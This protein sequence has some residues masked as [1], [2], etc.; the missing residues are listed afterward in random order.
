MISISDERAVGVVR[1]IQ[2][3][4]RCLGLNPDPMRADE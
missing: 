3:A 4:M 1:G 2:E